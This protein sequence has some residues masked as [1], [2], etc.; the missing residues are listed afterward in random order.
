MTL[1]VLYQK[2]IIRWTIKEWIKNVLPLSDFCSV[3]VNIITTWQKTGDANN[4]LSI[5]TYYIKQGLFY[6]FL[7]HIHLLYDLIAERESKSYRQTKHT[8]TE[9]LYMGHTFGSFSRAWR[10][11]A[12]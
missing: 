3:G 6:L 4:W 10:Q 9:E 11:I 7:S 8:Y 12:F 2:A 1:A 5:I